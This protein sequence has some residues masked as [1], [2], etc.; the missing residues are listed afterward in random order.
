[1]MLRPL[2]RAEAPELGQGN[3]V[4]SGCNRKCRTM[5]ADN[6]SVTLSASYALTVHGSP[7]S[8]NFSCVSSCA[9]P[10]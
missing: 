4:D 7:F 2:D 9:L 3:K 10:F 8:A 1:V 6:L 5:V